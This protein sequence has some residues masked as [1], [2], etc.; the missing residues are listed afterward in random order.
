MDKLLEALLGSPTRDSTSSNPMSLKS[1]AEANFPE[2]S[3]DEVVEDDEQQ[4]GRFFDKGLNGEQ[5]A[6]VKLCTEAG[7][8]PV[9]LIHGPFGTGKTRTLVG[10]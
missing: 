3:G 8:S 6:A 9:A 10:E 5:R 7:R 1:G 4:G 2:Y